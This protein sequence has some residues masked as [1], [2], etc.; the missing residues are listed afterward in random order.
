MCFIVLS[1]KAIDASLSNR[2]D[3]N[4]YYDFHLYIDNMKRGQTPFTPSLTV[5][6]QL[7]RVLD[8]IEADGGL[9]AVTAAREALAMRFRARLDGHGIQYTR[10]Y[11]S[12]CVTVLHTGS[13]DAEL[14]AQDLKD[15]YDITVATNSP[16]LKKTH[17]RISHMGNNTLD[18]M[19]RAAEAIWFAMRERS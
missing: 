4:L 18:E 13:V 17:F 7:D 12:N 16:P 9:A 6:Y 19:D 1:E 3:V 8:N 14:I 5:L 10:E 15:N 2:T 11:A